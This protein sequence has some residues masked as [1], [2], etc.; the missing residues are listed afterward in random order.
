MPKAVTAIVL[1]HHIMTEEEWTW[2]AASEDREYCEADDHLG[3]LC[4]KIKSN[5]IFEGYDTELVKYPGRSGLQFRFVAQAAGLGTIGINAFLF[6]PNWGPWVHL[7]VMATT[8]K[9]N[10]HPQFSGNEMCDRCGLCVSECPANAISDRGFEGLRCRSYREAIGEYKPYGPD[11]RYRYC[12]ICALV[13]PKGQ[14]P[15]PRGNIS[16]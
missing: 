12:I 11:R 7:R 2:Y 8:A 1:L 13:C 6:R 5:L 15:L 14:Q 3:E 4:E 16:A 10:I 9:L